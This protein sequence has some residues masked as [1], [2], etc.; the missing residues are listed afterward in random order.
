MKAIR[1]YAP[2]TYRAEHAQ[3]FDDT[4]L[5]STEDQASDTGKKYG[6]LSDFLSDLQ[7]SRKSKICSMIR[8]QVSS[9]RNKNR[10]A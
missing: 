7:E 5:V 1:P 3:N 2:K 6:T 8:T 4:V 10:E 9:S